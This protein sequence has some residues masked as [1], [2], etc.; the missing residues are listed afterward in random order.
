[1]KFRAQLYLQHS[2]SYER[3]FLYYK[4]TAL[5]TMN[6]SGFE[7]IHTD[8][9]ALNSRSLDLLGI[10]I[11]IYKFIIIIFLTSI[12]TNVLTPVHTYISK[13]YLKEK[14][15][16]IILNFMVHYFHFCHFNFQSKVIIKDPLVHSFLM[17][18]VKIHESC[19]IA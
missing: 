3:L 17:Y 8:Y 4:F 11:I 19:V 12:S 15:I 5:N 2:A 9:N 10:I 7:P 16:L 13:C 18:H 6:S 14:K 1:M